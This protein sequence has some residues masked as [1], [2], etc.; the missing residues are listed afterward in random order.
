MNLGEF[1][2]YYEPDIDMGLV[3]YLIWNETA[4]PMADWKTTVK[5]LYSAIRAYKNQINRCELCGVKIQHCMCPN[6]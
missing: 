1:A 4:Y 3:E 5:Q 2:K 6:L